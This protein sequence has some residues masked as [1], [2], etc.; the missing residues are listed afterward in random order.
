MRCAIAIA[1]V[2]CAPAAHAAPARLIG[3]VETSQSRDA[4]DVIVTESLVRRSDGTSA[5]VIQLGGVVDG[6]GLWVSHQ[7]PV[8]EV[9]DHVE[10]AAVNRPTAGGA[11]FHV[12]DGVAEARSVAPQDGEARYGVV[13]TTSKR[14]VWRASGCIDVAYGPSVSTAQ[15]AVIDAAF[16]VWSDAASCASLAF[17]RSQGSDVIAAEGISSI[18][19]HRTKWCR[20]ATR[21]EPELCYS[22]VASGITRLRFVDDPAGTDDGRILEADIELNAVDYTLIAPG[23]TMSAGDR[24]LDLLSVATHEVGH[25]LGLAHSCGTGTEPW[26]RDHEGQTVPACEGL[27]LDAPALRST[28]YYEIAPGDIGQRTLEGNDVVGLC[29][30]ARALTCDHPDVTGGCA[31]IPGASWLAVIVIIMLV[32]TREMHRQARADRRRTV[33]SGKRITQVTLS[34]RGCRACDEASSHL[35]S[36]RQ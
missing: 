33:R 17:T 13:R 2:L 20:P 22:P 7:P 25:L 10:L 12:L 15:A 34:H 29:S 18:H 24:V 8:L 30:T 16:Q 26:P 3:T 21:T 27:A 5:R 32:C 19:V 23:E 9:G 28:M 14:P 4:G 1:V 31:A 11:S 6:V 36:Y 35:H